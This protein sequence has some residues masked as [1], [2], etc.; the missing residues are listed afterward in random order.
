MIRPVTML[1]AL[2]LAGSASAQTASPQS[3][4]GMAPPVGQW[5]YVQAAPAPVVVT[6]GPTVLVA[7]PP[8]WDRCLAKIGQCL[9]NRAAAHQ[10]PTTMQ[11]VT[12]APATM[13]AAPI[14]MA[15]PVVPTPQASPVQSVTPSPSAKVSEA[16]PPAPILAVPDVHP[17]GILRRYG[18]WGM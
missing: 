18:P 10:H 16:A 11:V 17:N 14:G 3:P 7:S 2:G 13:P 1:L 12:Y 9:V 8:C 5:V 15:P 6:L 4:V